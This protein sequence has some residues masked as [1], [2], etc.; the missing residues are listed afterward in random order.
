MSNIF[1]NPL[2][3]NV[4]ISDISLIYQQIKY[5]INTDLEIQKDI[6]NDIK[7]IA[8]IILKLFY[9]KEVQNNLKSE[10]QFNDYIQSNEEKQ[11]SEKTKQF[12]KNCL[13]YYENTNENWKFVKQFFIPQSN[14]YPQIKTDQTILDELQI[15]QNFISENNIPSNHNI[16][17]NIENNNL[18]NNQLN[19]INNNKQN[20]LYTEINQLDKQ[21]IVKLLQGSISDLASNINNEIPNQNL[22]IQKHQNEQIQNQNNKQT[23]SN[24]NNLDINHKK[25][26]E[27]ASLLNNT[28]NNL[29]SNN[30]SNLNIQY[31][32]N[33]YNNSN[34]NSASSQSN[35]QHF[36][37]PEAQ[38]TKSVPIQQG[39]SIFAKKNQ[40]KQF[41][42]QMRRDS[43]LNRLVIEDEDEI[44]LY[45]QKKAKLLENT[46]IKKKNILLDYKT[47]FFQNKIQIQI[48][49]QI[50][51]KLLKKN[52]E[53]LKGQE[54]KNYL[55]D[56]MIYDDIK[57][58][59]KYDF[60]VIQEIDNQ[61]HIDFQ[62]E[63][64]S[65]KN[66][67]Q[68]QIEDYNFQIYFQLFK[69]KRQIQ[70]VYDNNKKQYLLIKTFQPQDDLEMEK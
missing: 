56:I 60:E 23:L 38:F 50:Q 54:Q 43:Y 36:F 44:S 39:K 48:N 11:L 24:K 19:I 12:L 66:A 30:I 62:N 22:N 9:G 28:N 59:K 41:T 34:Q 47:T 18:D 5:E 1:Y 20:Q 15:Q 7:T 32:N 27:T 68:N 57:Q 21:E 55:Y 53:L 10:Q 6:R 33:S 29:N 37:K 31:N 8:T 65:Q 70:K 25:Q 69:K 4:K 64:N 46:Q 52:E 2:T 17:S 40:K 45:Y 61:E 26:N 58:L 16:I 51:T 63:Q 35:F 67:F 3:Q 13:F 49:F 42:R 14:K